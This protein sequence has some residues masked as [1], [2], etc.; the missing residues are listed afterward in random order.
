MSSHHVLNTRDFVQ[1]LKDISLQQDECI[2]S[3][4]VKPLFTSVPIQPVIN[5]IHNKLTNDKDLQQRTSMAIHHII[6]LLEFCLKSTYFVFQEKYYKQ[7]EG[8]AMGSPLS[9]IV[10]NIFMDE[11]EAKA[12]STAP[13]TPSLWK[14]FVDGTFVVIK[15]VHKEEFFTHINFIEGGIQFTAENTRSVGSYALLR[16]LVIPQADGSLLTTEYR[17]SSH[18]NQYLQWDGHHAISAKYSVISTLFHRAKD[19]CS[20]KQQLDEEHEHLQK[21]LTTCKC[22]RWAL[23]MM[24]NNQ[25]SCPI[26]KQQKQGEEC[27]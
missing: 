16:P 15:S 1:Q 14:R 12:L 6:S 2:I 11:F 27:N 23:N 24:K 17:T 5:I 4:D 7:V 8:A 3:Y 25:C 9:P 26:Q 10:A 19:V 22:P 18:T 13:H 20:T 21:V